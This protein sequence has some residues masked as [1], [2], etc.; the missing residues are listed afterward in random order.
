MP[1]QV[2]HVYHD[3]LTELWRLSGTVDEAGR[4]APHLLVLSADAEAALQAFEAELEPRLGPGGDLEFLAD[5]ASKLAGAALRLAGILH[6]AESVGDGRPWDAVIGPETMCRALALAR[7][8]LVP[9]ARAAFGLMGA[10]EEV[11]DA[12]RILAW[13]AREGRTEFKRWQLYMDVK[14]LGRFPRMEALDRPLDR[15]VKHRYLRTVGYTGP[16]GRGRPPEP[17]YEVNPGWDRQDNLENLEKSGPGS[18]CGE[19]S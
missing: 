18:G 5:W 14:S 19:Y 7:D 13:V 9:H 10:D 16:R 11:E 1:A 3:R 8:Y 12:R 4:P 15:L 17:V 6:V 2:A